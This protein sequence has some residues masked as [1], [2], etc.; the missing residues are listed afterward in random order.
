LDYLAARFMEDAWSIKKLHRL[1]MLSSTYQQSS[2]SNAKAE[3]LDPGNQLL[4][5]MNRR[6]LDFESMRD[7]FLALSGKLDLAAG[8]RPVDITTEP[9]TSRRTVY[10]FVERQNLPGIFRT[11]DFASPDTTSPQRFSTT[12]PQ[13]ALFLMNSPFVVQQAKALLERPEVKACRSENERIEQL[14]RLAFLRSPEAD[15]VKLGH[16]F[17]QTKTI[18]RKPEPP[19]W[20]YGYGEYDAK[21]ARVK[22]FRSLPTYTKYGWQGSTNLPDPKLGWVILN[23]DGGHPGNDLQHAA[24]RRWHSSV[25]G[26][27]SISAE[28]E[29]PGDKGDG[30]RARIV[31]S[32]KGLLGEWTVQHSKTNTN[33][34]RIEVQAGD[35]IDFV[36]DCRSSV[37]FDSF[38]WAPQLKTKA[39]SAKGER[40]EWNAKTD[41]GG[42]PR[43]K[44][45]SLDAWTKYAQVLLLANELMFVD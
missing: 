15:E 6:R 32:R 16:Q 11:F 9:F 34:R 12:V 7:T 13:Q 3:K 42:P 19:I 21:T 43:E 44:P 5:R 25:D 31:S 22:S 45:K 10:G 2:L 40:A 14:Y 36:A 30:V 28:L 27:I 33:L 41:F 29:H 26:S 17:L 24:I 23:A 37:E 20:E 18:E 4:W 1:M 38:T 8:G 35:T 39:A